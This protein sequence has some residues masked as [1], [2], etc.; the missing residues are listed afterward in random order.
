MTVRKFAGSPARMWRL[1]ADAG[2]LETTS[3]KNPGSFGMSDWYVGRRAFEA[4]Q[5][6][7]GLTPPG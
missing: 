1:I 2:C 3:Y 5:R 4:N 6:P 7:L